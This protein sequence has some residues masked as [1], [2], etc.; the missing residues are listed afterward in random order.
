MSLPEAE[1]QVIKE[2]L[3]RDIWL[4]FALVTVQSC[5]VYIEMYRDSVI[6]LLHNSK[7]Q[8]ASHY[9]LPVQI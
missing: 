7:L 8:A 9:C 4:N 3:C 1:T 5:A 2:E 6:G